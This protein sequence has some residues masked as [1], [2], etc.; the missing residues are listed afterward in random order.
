T[1][2][3]SRALERRAV[4]EE[5][6]GATGVEE[7]DV[8]VLVEPALRDVAQEPREALAR[9]DGVQQYPLDSGQHPYRVGHG[10][11]GDAVTTA[12][13][14]IVDVHRVTTHPV[15]D[16]QPREGTRR[17]VTDELRLVVLLLA[18]TDPEHP[19]RAVHTPQPCHQTRL[20]ATAAR[21][22]DDPVDR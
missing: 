5:P 20:G 22:V 8:L 9:V 1:P 13:P 14:S 12:N 21:P 16:A 17:Q 10:V 6:D 3:R 11:G 18:H 4:A 7:H 15:V 2:S 19:R